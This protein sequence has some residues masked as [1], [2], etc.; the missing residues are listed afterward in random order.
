MQPI[1][2]AA[3]VEIGKG[4]VI[5]EVNRRAMSAVSDFE[6]IV[7]QS[8]P[9]DVLALYLYVPESDQ[10]VIRTVRIETP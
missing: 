8:R 2:A 3:D 1:S 10:R 9:G 6:E 4:Y 5:I 7:A